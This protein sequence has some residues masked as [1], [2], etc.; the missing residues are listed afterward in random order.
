MKIKNKMNLKEYLTH[1]KPDLL[2]RIENDNYHSNSVE[3]LRHNK[4][5]NYFKPNSRKV[6]LAHKIL[7]RRGNTT[8]RDKVK[9]DFSSISE[10]SRNQ[11]IGKSFSTQYSFQTGH[12]DNR[13]QNSSMK[14]VSN[15]KDIKKGTVFRYGEDKFEITN[16]QKLIKKKANRTQKGFFKSKN[17][18]NKMAKRPMTTKSR[19]SSIK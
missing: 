2:M 14:I 18:S 11:L 12:E 10:H 17:A 3:N 5:E 19:E 6:R 16:D 9:P 8:S 13:S 1:S 4:G 7:I 15:M